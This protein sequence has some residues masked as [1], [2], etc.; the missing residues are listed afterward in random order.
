MIFLPAEN[1]QMVPSLSTVPAAELMGLG[2]LLFYSWEPWPQMYLKGPLSSPG[3]PAELMGLGPV[4]EG[5]LYL[6][7]SAVPHAKFSTHWQRVAERAAFYSVWAGPLDKTIS[8][9]SLARARSLPMMIVC[10]VL[11]DIHWNH[12]HQTSRKFGF[13]L[14]NECLVQTWARTL[15]KTYS[16]SLSIMKDI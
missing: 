10:N 1:E 9:Q 2:E 4:Q 14:N 11:W 8:D 6:L 5:Q 7:L 3:T 15:H 16:Y 12:S 13:N